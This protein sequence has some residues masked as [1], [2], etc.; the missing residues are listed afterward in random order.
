[1]L[2]FFAR[3]NRIQLC[4]NCCHNKIE[5]EI[6][7]HENHAYT[8]VKIGL[9]NIFTISLNM[10][11]I[12]SQ[13]YWKIWQRQHCIRRNSNNSPYYCYHCDDGAFIINI[14]SKANQDLFYFPFYKWWWSQIQG[15]TRLSFYLFYCKIT[16]L[17]II[18]T[19]PSI[20]VFI[21]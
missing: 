11:S 5:F 9:W 2:A 7:L 8:N 21:N 10:S 17:N 3:V 19:K 14:M 15:N 6:L 16:Q 20:V 13:K 4:F 12:F 1:M 18:F